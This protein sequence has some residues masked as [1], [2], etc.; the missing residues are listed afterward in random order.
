MENPHQYLPE[1]LAR[2]SAAAKIAAA[3]S[4]C[5]DVRVTFTILALR[6]RVL[7]ELGARERTFWHRT[8]RGDGAGCGGG[9][10]HRCCHRRVED[11]LAQIERDLPLR[12]LPAPS[13]TSASVA[14]APGRVG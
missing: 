14:P 3:H 5:E 4:N 11:A 7:S 10:S 9:R 8:K 2:L 1:R 6:W 12:S 13:G